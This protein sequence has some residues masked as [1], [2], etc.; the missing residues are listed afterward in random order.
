MTNKAKTKDQKTESNKNRVLTPLKSSKS[1]HRASSMEELMKAHP[2]NIK[3]L[4]RGD[5]IEGIVKKL[6][7]KEILLDIGGKGDALVIEYDKKNAESLLSMLSIGDKVTASVISPEAEEGYPVLSL[8]G[9]LAEKMNLKLQ[10]LFKR[11]IAFDV[12]VLDI[13]RGGFFVE[14]DEGIKGFLPNSQALDK[15]A[16]VNSS[17]QVKII[18]LDKVKRRIIFSQKAAF[19]VTDKS[20]IHKYIKKGIIIDGIVKSVSPYGVYVEIKPSKD[21]IIEGFLHVSEISHERVQDIESRFSIGDK[22]KA[23]VIN[24]DGD[25][26]RINLSLKQLEKDAFDKAKDKYKPEAIIKAS[27]KNI[28]SRGITIELEKNI[29]GFMQNSKIPAGSDY[30]VGDSIEVEVIDVDSRR[31]QVNVTPVLKKKFVGYR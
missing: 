26:N 7:P 19:Y 2:E 16:G 28:S 23:I 22:M 30:K 8:R 1:S 9:M 25:N 31:R 10:D 24:T 6:D 27:I 12:K 3:K 18:E 20:I 13:T 17:L 5:R 15:D 4:K 29:S 14:A 21:I 11:K